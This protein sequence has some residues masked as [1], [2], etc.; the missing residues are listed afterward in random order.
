MN[1]HYYHVKLDRKSVKRMV[2]HIGWNTPTQTDWQI[3]SGAIRR[4]AP[5]WA[6]DEKP[7]SLYKKQNKWEEISKDRH[8]E[9]R[10]ERGGATSQNISQ[11]SQTS[12]RQEWTQIDR[13]SFYGDIKRQLD[14]KICKSN[15]A[16]NPPPVT[17]SSNCPRML[18]TWRNNLI[19]QISRKWNETSRQ[20]KD[21]TR[22]SYEN[23]II[24]IDQ[25]L[26]NICENWFAHPLSQSSWRSRTN[27]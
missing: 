7:T 5:K 12:E 25:V 23:D 17:S 3:T 24:S 26:T 13:W 8:R 21:R 2:E 18:I 6:E 1:T 20:M 10:S 16:E 14:L 22:P 27:W 19:K 15:S 11:C 9:M 4:K